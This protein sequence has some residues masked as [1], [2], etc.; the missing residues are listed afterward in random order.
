[1]ARPASHGLTHHTI[2]AC[3][4]GIG[5]L[6][7]EL[8]CIPAYALLPQWHIPAAVAASFGLFPQH[9]PQEIFHMASIAFVCLCMPQL[10]GIIFL[11]CMDVFVLLCFTRHYPSTSATGS[12]ST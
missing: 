2:L 7:L 8:H 3:C 11:T 6:R 9:T 4:E 12:T 10:H 5:L 1:M